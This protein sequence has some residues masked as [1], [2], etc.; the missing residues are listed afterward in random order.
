M[1]CLEETIHTPTQSPELAKGTETQ[2]LGNHT[3]CKCSIPQY[4]EKAKLVLRA[5]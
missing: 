4:R 5:S 2:K 3:E 1:V